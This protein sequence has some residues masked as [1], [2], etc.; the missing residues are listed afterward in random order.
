MH[1]PGFKNEVTDWSSKATFEDKYNLDLET[2][3]KDAFERM[4]EKLDLLLSAEIL[5]LQAFPDTTI[6]Y[7]QTDLKEIW[8]LHEF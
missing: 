2:L 7:A 8:E 4:D 3:A 5:I 6:D 1:L